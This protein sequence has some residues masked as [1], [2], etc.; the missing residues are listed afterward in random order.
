MIKGFPINCIPINRGGTVRSTLTDALPATLEAK[1]LFLWTG[2]YNED[3]LLNDLGSEEI[4]VTGKDWITK[5]IPPITTAT[6]AVPDN[7]TFLGAD[8]TD[9]FWFNVANTLLQKSHADLIASETERTFI[10]YSDFPPYNVYA[11][12]ILKDGEILTDEE[13][14]IISKYFKLWIFYFGVFSDYGYLKDNRT[15]E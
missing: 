12:G 4:A 15:I 9:D 14:N 1:F 5:Y 8:G 10:K 6:F 2:K 7:A 13:K 11:I 3:N